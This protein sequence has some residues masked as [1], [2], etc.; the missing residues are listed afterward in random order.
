MA[1]HARKRIGLLTY[2]GT[3]PVT[4]PIGRDVW[5][6]CL[7]MKKSFWAMAGVLYLDVGTPFESMEEDKDHA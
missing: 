3:N 6:E 2:L 1:S 5:P 7:I 4:M